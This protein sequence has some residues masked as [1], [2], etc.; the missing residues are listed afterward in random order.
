MRAASCPGSALVGTGG[1]ALA[2][3]PADRVICAKHA[4]LSPLPPEGAPVIRFRTTGHAAEMAAQQGVRSADLLEHGMV[5]RIVDERPDA[6]D[7]PEEFLRR[8]GA[9]LAE[10][11][12]AVARRPVDEL[13]R[14]RSARYRNLG[15]SADRADRTDRAEPTLERQ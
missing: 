11:L 15:L 1:G 6:A 13:R 8:M 14:Q 7:E 2:L 3:L 12:A 10:E 9:A 4:W 5:D